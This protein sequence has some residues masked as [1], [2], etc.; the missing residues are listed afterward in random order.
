[1]EKNDFSLENKVVISNE[2]IRETTTKM[3]TIP[4]KILRVFISCI[5]TNRP[6]RKINV[7]RKELYNFLE[8]EESETNYQHIKNVVTNNLQEKTIHL[9]DENNKEIV[10]SP[11]SKITYPPKDSNEPIEV[12]FNEFLEPYLINLKDK[13]LQ[14]DIAN[15]KHLNSKHSIILYEYLLAEE[16][17]KHYDNHTYKIPIERIRQITDTTKKYKAF[18]DFEKYVIAPAVKEINESGVEFLTKY[19]KIKQWRKV[20]HISFTLRPRTSWKEKDY[21]EIANSEYLNNKI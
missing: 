7:D 13:F 16:R 2:L 11:F 17:S 10:I 4:L 1:M 18:K 14:Y 8:T 12:I 21:N 15:L 20:S 19:E 6:S 5:D 3:N 9:F